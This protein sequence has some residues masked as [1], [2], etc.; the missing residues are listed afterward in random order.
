MNADYDPLSLRLFLAICEEGGVV[1]AAE[2]ESTVP[3]AVSKRMAALEE[4]VGLR[5]LQRGPS[6]MAPTEAGKAFAQQAREVLEVMARMHSVLAAIASGGEGSVRIVASLAVISSSLSSDLVPLMRERPGIR[7]SLREASSPEMVRQVREGSADLAVCWDAADLDGLN[8]LPYRDDHACAVV[9]ADHPMA[10]RKLLS[11]EETLSHDFISAM[12]GSMMEIMLRRQAFAL[13]KTLS[14][15]V[16]VQ[17]FDGVVRAVAA[18]LGLGILPREVISPLLKETLPIRVIPLSD[19]WATRH[20]VLAFRAP[21]Y[22]SQATLL[23]AQHL[24]AM[25]SEG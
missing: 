23:L 18:G 24:S 25:G 14:A 1:R 21:P 11:F 3:S 8:T 5:L 9:P 20:F 19:S 16:E 7:I 4:K 6:G 15:R 12:P 2:R 10:R 13:G 22:S 17:S